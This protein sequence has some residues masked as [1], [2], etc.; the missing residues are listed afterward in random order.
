MEIC[1]RT[2]SQSYYE[3]TVNVLEFS[4]FLQT[5][6]LRIK[7]M[8]RKTS[9]KLLIIINPSII[10]FVR[11]VNIF[12]QHISDSCARINYLLQANDDGPDQLGD[13]DFWL[14]S[15][16]S[17]ARR[18]QARHRTSRNKVDVLTEHFRFLR[19]SFIL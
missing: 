7:F 11:T 6:E 12:Y 8:R 10:Q 19:L 1:I 14:V 4:A 17:F 2:S 15:Y 9:T 5:T 3:Y 13:F 16:P 18:M